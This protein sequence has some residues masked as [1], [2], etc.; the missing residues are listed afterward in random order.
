MS[1][2]EIALLVI[3]VTVSL[4]LVVIVLAQ[5]D[6]GD[7]LGGL[8]GG[9]GSNNYGNRSGNVLTKATTVLGTLFF[10]SSLGLAF[11]YRSPATGDVEAAARAQSI[12]SG[13]N[14]LSDEP[15]E[16]PLLDSSL[17]EFMDEDYSE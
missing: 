6:Q 12:Q 16:T 5:D 11:L 15:A 13:L 1:F 9:G 4:L 14:I 17:F 8:F 3:F 7:S 10:V 2:L